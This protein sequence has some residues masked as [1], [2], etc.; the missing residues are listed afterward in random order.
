M[1]LDARSSDALTEIV[2]IG[3]GYSAGILQSM[4]DC[5]IEV[6]I[7]RAQL[8]RAEDLPGQLGLPVASVQLGFSGYLVGNA[9]MLFP[10]PAARHLAALLHQESPDSPQLDFLCGSTL[11]EVGN[12]VLNGIV[13][14][15]SNLLQLHLSYQ[16]PEYSELPLQEW[17]GR[18]Q[19][20]ASVLLVR[21]V[22]SVENHPIQGELL[23][24]LDSASAQEFLQRIP[25]PK[26]KN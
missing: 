22:I 3:V 26:I 5:H 21:S 7:S 17:L 23:L 19:G 9:V 11:T 8:L 16:V 12:I 4:L 1:K 15:I 10:R 2:N 18:R 13:G 6:H 14:T 25:D 20:L 24:C